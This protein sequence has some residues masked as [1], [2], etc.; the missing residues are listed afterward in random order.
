[1]SVLILIGVGRKAKPFL[2]KK[3]LI[4]GMMKLANIGG[5][6]SPVRKDLRVRVP[7]PAPQRKP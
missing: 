5:L 6:K 2:I 4:A 1:M 7:L 3:N